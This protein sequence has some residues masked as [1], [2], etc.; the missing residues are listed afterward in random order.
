VAAVAVRPALSRWGL[1]FGL[2]AVAGI[3]LRVWAY[4][5]EMGTPNADE[6]VV[7]LMTRHIVDGELTT[8]YWGQAYG[9]SQEALLTAPLFWVSDSSWFGLR[10]IPIILSAVAAFLVWRVGRRTIGEP[11]AAVAAAVFW[12]WPAFNVLQ[13]THQQGFYASNVVYCALLLLLALRIVERPDAVRVG[14]FGLVLGLA[15]WQTPQIV[16][17]AAGVIAWTI[18]KQPRSLRRLWVA[19]PLAALGAL[20]WIVWNAEHGWESLSQPDYGD[21]IR[22]VRLL[23]SP[24]LPMMIGLRAPFSA[25]L[26]LPAAI[27]YVVYA[28]LVALFVYGA[29]KTRHRNV[30]I[31]YFVAIV[32]PFIYLISPKTSWAVGTPRFIVVLTPVLALL[33][34]QFATTFRRGAAILL[35]VGVVSVVTLHRIDRWFRSEPPQTTHVKGWGPRHIAQWVPRDLG[36]LVSALDRLRLD[37][38]YADYWLAH[39]LT[40]DTRERI[41]AA[42]S[43]FTGLRVED[44]QAVPLSDQKARHPP[45]EREVEAARHGFVF[46]REIVDSVPIVGRLEQQ[47]YRPHTI[48]SYVVYAPTTEGES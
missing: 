1:L 42:E 17:L 27:V 32:F 16:P 25:E 7:G 15:F 35:L 39:R 3:A 37:R 41:V 19:A 45:Y 26:L 34:A 24:V 23:A 28:G 9:G 13:L 29:V 44:G 12:I 47:G 20:P 18:W 21:E 10:I 2:T 33:L 40:F 5:A 46:Y 38:V 36:P 6:A 4:R 31:L 14:L 30:S 8:F 11:A 22:S 43:R 48:G